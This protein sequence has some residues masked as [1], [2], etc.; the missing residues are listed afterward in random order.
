M[1]WMPSFERQ[2]CEDRLAEIISSAGQSWLTECCIFVSS[3]F[4]LAFS[5]SR[6]ACQYI[7]IW[8]NMYIYIYT[9]TH[10]TTSQLHCTHTHTHAGIHIHMNIHTHVCVHSTLKNIC[11]IK[12]QYIIHGYLQAGPLVLVTRPFQP[13]WLVPFSAVDMRGATVENVLSGGVHAK[14]GSNSP[15]AGLNYT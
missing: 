14:N 8:L 15:S 5:C 3:W 9:H 6:R 7:Y 13:A 10:H 11:T 12:N 2:T 4:V 1:A